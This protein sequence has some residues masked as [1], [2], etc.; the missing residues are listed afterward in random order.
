MTHL[1]RYFV[2]AAAVLSSLTLG[3]CG[4]GH[5]MV[6]AGVPDS[7]FS[8]SIAPFD[9]AVDATVPNI[10]GTYTGTFVAT[11]DG[12]SGSGTI[13]IVVKQSGSKVS[14]TATLSANGK[15][16]TGDW[17]GT[18]ARTKK[19]VSVKFVTYDYNGRNATGHGN[20]IGKHFNGKAY[21]P[22]SGK[23]PAVTITFKTLK[24]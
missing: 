15:S 18:A 23:N 21:V 11:E 13:K 12:R 24:T 7:P 2:F 10:A 8:K 22:A 19:G 5:G 4:G 9:A 14:G 1:Q 3:A 6:P 20:V 17:S 16:T